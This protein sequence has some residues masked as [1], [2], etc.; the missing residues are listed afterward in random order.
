MV[1][2]GRFLPEDIVVD[3]MRRLD[4]RNGRV[5]PAGAPDIKLDCSACEGLTAYREGD[6][7]GVYCQ[8]CGKRHSRDSLVDASVAGVG[9]E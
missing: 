9:E 1:L 3:T 5:T 6:Q 8:S 4:M 7:D 2:A